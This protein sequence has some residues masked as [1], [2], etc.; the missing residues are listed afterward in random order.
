[1]QIHHLFGDFIDIDNI[2]L[3]AHSYGLFGFLVG[4]V[5]GSGEGGGGGVG[6]IVVVVGPGIEGLMERVIVVGFV[7]GGC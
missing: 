1:M 7:V 3:F 5:F 2:P 6:E 4:F